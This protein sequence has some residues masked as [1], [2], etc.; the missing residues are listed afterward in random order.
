MTRAFRRVSRS[1]RSGQT[2]FY[3]WLKLFGREVT[4]SNDEGVWSEAFG[5]LSLVAREGSQAPGTPAGANFDYIT[6]PV[7]NDESRVAFSA[8]LLRGRGGVT[9]SNDTGIWS[10]GSGTLARVAR[11]GGSAP[12]TPAGTL[13]GEFNVYDVLALNAAGRYRVS[14]QAANRRQWSYIVERLWNLV[15]RRWHAHPCGP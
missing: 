9:S 8:S 12:G 7:L 5:M 15:G 2:A 10:E 14:C 3:A 13:F 4:P 1:T 11:E 6:L